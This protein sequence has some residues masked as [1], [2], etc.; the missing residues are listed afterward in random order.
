M[1][2]H[3][4]KKSSVKFN[5]FYGTVIA[6][7]EN[8]DGGV[9]IVFKPRDYRGGIFENVSLFVKENETEDSLFFDFLESTYWFQVCVENKEGEM[10][11]SFDELKKNIMGME[12]YLKIAVISG[13]PYIVDISSCLSNLAGYGF[14]VDSPCGP[15]KFLEVTDTP[16]SFNIFDADLC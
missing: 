4:F 13:E 5:V 12:A 3:D 7:K 6:V 1:K 8:S 16:Q 2:I 15:V 14:L 11:F 9:E 10:E